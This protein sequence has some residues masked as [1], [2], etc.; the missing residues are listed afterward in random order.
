M[1]FALKPS[2]TLDLLQQ[3][4]LHKQDLNIMAVLQDIFHQ[5][6]DSLEFCPW[7]ERQ[8]TIVYDNELNRLHENYVLIRLHIIVSMAAA[9]LVCVLQN[10]HGGLQ[11]GTR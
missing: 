1:N 4:T 2:Q 8:S 10:H 6:C 11:R 9:L 3:F 5:D 7:P